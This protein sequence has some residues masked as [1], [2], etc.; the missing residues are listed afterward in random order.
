MYIDPGN[1]C[2]ISTFM[3]YGHDQF[4]IN[5]QFIKAK[6]KLNYRFFHYV[7]IN[8]YIVIKNQ[9]VY[10]MEVWRIFNN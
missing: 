10:S 8:N 1:K 5:Y 9:L 4:M 7:M 3:N 2:H 6:T